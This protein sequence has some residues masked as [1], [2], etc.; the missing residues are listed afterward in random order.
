MSILL[1]ERRIKKMVI[2]TRQKDTDMRQEQRNPP[3]LIELVVVVAGKTESF[4]TA[5]H[6][7]L[8]IAIPSSQVTHVGY[9][10][11]AGNCNVHLSHV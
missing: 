7:W 9:L 6:F 4:G 1:D 10:R 3:T 8:E 2:F 5:Q 11:H